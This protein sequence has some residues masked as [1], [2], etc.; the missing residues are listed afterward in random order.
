MFIQ[1]KKKKLSTRWNSGKA[2]TDAHNVVKKKKDNSKLTK[3]R[4][5]K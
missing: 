4:I 2:H 5:F 3:L 1:E